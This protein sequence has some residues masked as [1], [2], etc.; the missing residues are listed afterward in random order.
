MRKVAITNMTGARNRGCQALVDSILLGLDEAIPDENVSVDLYSRDTDFDRDCFGDRVSAVRPYGR[1]STD[2][3]A[4]STQRNMFWLLNMLPKQMSIA[5]SMRQL[6]DVDLIIATGGDVFTS[7]YGDFTTHARVLQVGPPVALLAQ[8]VGPFTPQ[9]EE[10]FRNST[11]NLAFCTVREAES[12]E[13][14]RH[15][16]PDVP[17]AQTAD[18]AFLLPATDPEESRYILEVEHHFPIEGRRLIALSVS[19]GIL[20]F[21][22]G[23]DAETYV[24]EVAAFV[25]LVNA[26]GFSVILVPHVQERSPSNNDMVACRAVLNACADPSA[27]LLLSVPTLTASDY[28]GI[29]GLC[30]ALVGART[31]ATIASLSQGI[32]TVS[33][34]YSR[35]AWGIMRDYYGPELGKA[36]TVD[37]S[38][39]DR[40]QLKLALELAMANGQ[41]LNRAMEMKRLA[42]ANFELVRS[43][44]YDRE[45]LGEEAPLLKA[46]EPLWLP[47][48]A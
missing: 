8:T 15:L 7:D 12:L 17:V 39:L 44:L 45:A 34:A 47:A 11:E 42:A 18:V 24:R 20:T 37:V 9:A 36:L 6:G 33:I 25:N 3:W 43:F 22:D 28:K 19:S 23:L 4:P 16:V 29:I 31:H 13:Y 40:Y 5:P 30:D 26:E 21:R 10:F 38:A 27:N 46:D 14:L 48:S 41:T 2:N 32:P 35:K 1:R